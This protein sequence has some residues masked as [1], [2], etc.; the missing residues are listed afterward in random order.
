MAKIF[1][2]SPRFMAWLAKQKPWD[3]LVYRLSLRDEI[4][5]P[6]AGIEWNKRIAELETKLIHNEDDVAHVLIDVRRAKGHIE[7][8]GK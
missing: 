2:E 8:S 1:Y 3:E 5:D 6:A 7:L 4:R